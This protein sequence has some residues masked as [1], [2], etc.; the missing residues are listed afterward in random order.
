MI[1][2]PLFRVEKLTVLGTSRL[3]EKDVKAASKITPGTHFLR[4]RAQEVKANLSVLS[5]VQSADVR[6]RI[7]GELIITIT[8]RQPVGYIPVREGFYSFDRSGVLLE[9]VTD[10]KEVDLPVLT[11]LDLS[12]WG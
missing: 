6:V 4:I 5:W 10:P 11:G 8:E 1:E 12:D 2:S 7:P 9:V 3:T